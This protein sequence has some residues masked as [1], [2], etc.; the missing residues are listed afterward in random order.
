LPNS[1]QGNNF[2][3]II[4]PIIN[5]FINHPS[6][7]SLFCLVLYYYFF[8]F[9]QFPI[10]QLSDVLTELD[11]VCAQTTRLCQYAD[12]FPKNKKCYG[13]RHCSISM[14]ILFI[15]A[16]AL[17]L[18]INSLFIHL[19]F[20]HSYFYFHYNT[21]YSICSRSF[22]YNRNKMYTINRMGK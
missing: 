3:L 18:V 5:P 9:L 17:F 4:N 15:F 8:N 12:S 14:F 1:K 16:N 11:G 7:I 13:N 22:S 19:S 2:K 10:P 6:F 21:V 20:I